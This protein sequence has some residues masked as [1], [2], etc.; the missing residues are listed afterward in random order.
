MIG[1]QSRGNLAQ[2]TSVDF[3]L[4]LGALGALGQ[5]LDLQLLSSLQKG[6]QLL[7]GNIHLMVWSHDVIQAMCKL[8]NQP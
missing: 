3:L 7:L 1:H 6:W 8:H 2:N 5:P 4:I